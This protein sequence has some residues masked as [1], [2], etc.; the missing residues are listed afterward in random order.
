MPDWM[1]RMKA[2]RL[3]RI[4][5]HARR[6]HRVTACGLH[7]LPRR[8]LPSDNA[9]HAVQC[10]ARMMARPC[11][12]TL[13]DREARLDAMISTVAPAPTIVCAIP[14]VAS[15]STARPAPTGT[16][17]NTVFKTGLG[18]LPPNGCV[19][20]LY[21]PPRVVP[22]FPAVSRSLGGLAPTTTAAASRAGSPRRRLP[23]G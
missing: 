23:N 13:Q 8:S 10:A 19:V 2:N 7:Q 17:R 3:P 18:D 5:F 6:S 9:E 11:H 20:V 16:K 1:R 12:G 22:G 15:A 21:Q 14:P 4:D